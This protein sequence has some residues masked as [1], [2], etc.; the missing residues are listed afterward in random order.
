MVIIGLGTAGCGIAKEFSAS[1]KKVYIKQE[2]FPKSCTDEESFEANCPNFFR[3]KNSKFRNRE[4]DE[5]W[6]FVCG[7]SLCSSATLRILE[8]I[9]H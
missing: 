2:D 5:C 6:L 8:T 7:G 4:F 1:Y 9:R 3:G